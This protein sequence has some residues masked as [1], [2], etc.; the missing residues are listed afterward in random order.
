M[1]ANSV[2]R[3]AVPSAIPGTI[4]VDRRLM[5]RVAIPRCVV[6]GTPNR[7]AET[8]GHRE[9]CCQNNLLVVECRR[10]ACRAGIDSRS[11]EFEVVEP[12][13]SEGM[14]LLVKERDRRIGQRE[15]SADQIG[16]MGE[17]RRSPRK[18]VVHGHIQCE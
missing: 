12:H 5:V 2:R 8:T 10:P 18:V 14:H 6:V 1:R 15:T 9:C 13:L 4:L 16:E 7:A 17:L 11:L 3:F